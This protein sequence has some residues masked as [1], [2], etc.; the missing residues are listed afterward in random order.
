MRA[1]RAGLV[2]VLVIGLVVACA[3]PGR[4]ATSVDKALRSPP[5]E[6][7]PAAELQPAIEAAVANG[8]ASVMARILAEGNESGLAYPPRVTRKVIGTKSVPARRVSYEHPVYEVEYA[9][10]EQLVPETSAGQPTGGF[11]R[12]KVRVPVRQKVVGKQTRE[13]LVPDPEGKETM[14]VAEYGPGGPDVYE[15][16]Q[17]GLNGMALYVLARAGHANHEATERLAQSLSEKISAYGAPDTTFDVA[18]LAAGFTALGKDSIHAWQ[19]EKLVSKLIDGQIREK[20]DPR[21]L[22]GPVCIHYPYF[23]KLFE[24]QGQLHQQLEVE[25]PKMLE[26]TPPQQQEALIKQGKEMRKVYFDFLKAYRAASSQGARMMEITRAWAADEQTVLPGLPLYVYNRVVADVDST[27]AALFALAAAEKAGMLPDETERVAIRGRKVHAPEKTE[28]TLKLAGAAL[29]EAIAKDGGCRALTLQAINRGFEKS[30]LPIP[31]LPWKDA[32]PPLLDL[33][34]GITCA[35]GLVAVEALA[36]LDPDAAKPVAERREPMRDRVLALAQRWYDD[37]AV[38]SS[39][40]WHAPLDTVKVTDGDL[41]KSPTLSLPKAES[42]PAADLPWGGRAASYAVLPGF[43]VAF[44]EAEGDRRLEHPVFRKVAFRLVGL[45][46]AHGQ[47]TAPADW[48]S[49]GEASLALERYAAALHKQFQVTAPKD[50]KHEF[51][52]HQLI[53]GHLA[54]NEDGQRFATLASLLFLLPSI[55]GPAKLAGVPILPEPAAAETEG[56]TPAKKQPLPPATA[57]ARG[58]ERPNAARAALFDAILAALEVKPPAAAPVAAAP[59]AK[60]EAAA[61]A[62]PAPPA[63]DDGLGKVEDLLKPA[64]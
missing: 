7:I 49:S 41:A 25:L 27:A 32:W 62:E 43:A 64:P 29:G 55:D 39:V 56:D 17:F 45:Q 30:R 58:V 8:V 31:G 6:A 13:H 5:A 60:P 59:P 9:D 36:T 3:I 61:P 19:A 63:E 18:W 26:R 12:K 42:R 44:G 11:V 53:Y 22:W 21:G 24:M 54:S 48:F 50:P 23:A 28:A 4:A 34:T 35:S 20:G 1:A 46:D 14:Q 52:F 38:G 40:R 51:T 37:A 47:W 16:N 33:E 57:A 2:D 10:V 15:A